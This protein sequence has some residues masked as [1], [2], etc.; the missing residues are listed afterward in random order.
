MMEAFN[1]CLASP[2][3][4]SRLLGLSGLLSARSHCGVGFIR[5]AQPARFTSKSS[6]PTCRTLRCS[7]SAIPFDVSPPP[8]EE[9]PELKIAEGVDGE[10]DI[11]ETFADDN[12]AI[13]AAFDEVAI[14]DLSHFGRLRVTGEDRV[15]FLHNQSTAK[16]DDLTEG[17]GCDTVLV[18]ATARTIDIAHA[19]VMKN[20]VLLFLSPSTSK[21]ITEMLNKYEILYFIIL[22]N[23]QSFFGDDPKEAVQTLLVLDVKA[24]VT[25]TFFHPE[26]I[27]Y[28]DK[29]EIHDIT[30]QTYFFT[31][32][33]PKSSTVVASFLSNGNVKSWRS[34]WATVCLLLVK[35]CYWQVNGTPVTI[36]VGSILFKDGFS[37]MLSSASA[38]SVWRSLLSHGAIPMGINAWERLR[39]LQGR[40][41]PG[42]ELT[43]DYNVLEAG[44][45]MAVSVDKGCYKGQET[46]SRLITYDGVKQRLWGIRL[47]GQA[48]PGSSIMQDGNKVGVL[49]SYSI[50]RK[51]GDHVGLAYVKRR[52]NSAE[53]EVGDVKG[54]LI[55]APFLSYSNLG[56]GFS[57]LCP[58][59]GSFQLVASNRPFFH[60]DA[61]M[62]QGEPALV[63]QWYRFANGSTSNNVVRASSSKHFDGNDV[64][65]GMRNRTL[66]DQDQNIR[67]LSSNSSVSH[68]K[69]SFA[70]S[71]IYSSF[72]RSRD[73]N[74]DKNFDRRDSENRSVFVDNGFNCRVSSPKSEKDDLRNFESTIEGR[75]VE[76]WSKRLGSSGNNSVPHGGAAI[77]SISS[78]AF[79]KDFPTLRVDGRQ[80]FS[81][82][83]GVSPLGVRT[84]VQSLPIS[85]P[86]IIGTSVLAE[87]PVKVETTGTVSSPVPQ[88]ASIG[89]VSAAGS[90]MAE[91]L[92]QPPPQVDTLQLSVDTQRIEELT[93]KK[94]KQ[95]IPVTPMPKASSSS[96]IEKAKLKV[97]R[98][99]EF[100]HLNK[101]G[102]QPH[103]NL[104]VRPPAKFDT[105]KTAVPGNFQVL[106]REKN[107]I[108]PTAKNGL[109]VSK[110]TFG[111]VPAAAVIPL[112]SPTN[113]RLR[114][115]SRNGVSTQNSSG[116]RKPLF[117]AQNRTDFFN[118]L[119][120]KSLT[121]TSA[122]PESASVLS[123]SS[124]EIA[125][126]ENK[127]ITSPLDASPCSDVTVDPEE[128]AFLQSLGWDKN[129]GE[130]ALTE[131][132]INAFLKK[133]DKQ[134][135]FKRHAIESQQ[136][137]EPERGGADA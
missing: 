42:R 72:R 46:I 132:E 40:P 112:K 24:Y 121:C 19:W 43:K 7:P 32:M 101:T 56:E 96:L 31:L 125:D 14:A 97:A 115:D 44:L 62:E 84:S 45:S 65:F 35:N 13:D 9:D 134:R 5:S 114:V 79:E 6:I 123:P 17:V 102:Q 10:Y 105:T 120:K 117:Q 131:E 83:A 91:T 28:A 127:K 128:E 75:Q 78:T 87:V 34:C 76:P 113:Q 25:L 74:Q 67:S 119:R 3:H 60:A 37:F 133:Y 30:K 23:N 86:V 136:E 4:D 90:T 104:T 107:E 63:P 129:A 69:S 99:G 93:L 26:Y 52:I 108:S 109:G 54:T 15:Q 8:I 103:V 80:G 89:Q 81:D 47:S 29:V 22:L 51:D 61:G 20:A 2:V 55:D 98:K 94:C 12:M 106:Y 88:A 49:S 111:H 85:S 66:G 135:P 118:L 124:L 116:E 70:K 122:V 11:A 39:V 57:V 21:S 18:T 100:G 59:R 53:V 58:F 48:E 110:M 92:A 130:D 27:F 50:G 137:S 71:Q 126:V 33:G 68:N 1:R 82:G 41:A 77:S 95:L 64:D 38:R 36:G 73:R 16:F